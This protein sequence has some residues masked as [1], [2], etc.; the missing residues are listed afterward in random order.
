MTPYKTNIMADHSKAVAARLSEDELVSLNHIMA[1]HGCKNLGDL[2]RMLIGSKIALNAGSIEGIARDVAE[3]KEKLLTIVNKLGMAGSG[4][5]G[6]PLLL[7]NN[8]GVNDSKNKYE[9]FPASDPQGIIGGLTLY[10]LPHSL[11]GA[12][13]CTSG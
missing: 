9:V 8:T 11:R 7:S 6:M 1:R 3:V 12:C 4:E 2:L 13:C 10:L 5:N